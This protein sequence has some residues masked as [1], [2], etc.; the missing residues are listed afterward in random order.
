MSIGL[1]ISVNDKNDLKNNHDF[2][3]GTIILKRK[4]PKRGIYI[5]Y[6]YKVNSVSYQKNQNLSVNE[7]EVNLGDKFEV[8]YSTKRPK[9]SEIN[10]NKRI[11]QNY[12]K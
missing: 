12:F 1:F 9:N 6:K 8:K 10:F 3:T 5:R 4:I 2:T 11:N 7:V